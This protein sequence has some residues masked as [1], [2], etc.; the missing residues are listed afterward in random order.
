MIV[1]QHVL[2]FISASVDCSAEMLK[3]DALVLAKTCRD[4]VQVVQVQTHVSNGPSTSTK[5]NA[6]FWL[7]ERLLRNVQHMRDR[8]DQKSHFCAG[9]RVGFCHPQHFGSS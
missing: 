7:Y 9:R 2:I 3:S 5:E 4:A 1:R 6:H 8:T